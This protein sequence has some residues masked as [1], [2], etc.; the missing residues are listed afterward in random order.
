M[1]AGILYGC[2]VSLMLGVFFNIL[3]IVA[4][5]KNTNFFFPDDST[6]IG[7]FVSNNCETMCYHSNAFLLW[8]QIVMT[9][10]VAMDPW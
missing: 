9:K 3:L 5:Q 6:V 7:L 8:F 1:N 10:K 2:F 4:S